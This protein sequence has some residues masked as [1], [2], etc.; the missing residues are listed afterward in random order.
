MFEKEANQTFLRGITTVDVAT[1]MDDTDIDEDTW[2]LLSLL[3]FF[4]HFNDEQ[5]FLAQKEIHKIMR[6]VK[7]QQNLDTYS[8]CSFASF[9]N[10]KSVP[11]NSP[12]F[13]TN[14]LN[15]RVTSTQNEEILS[16]YL[17]S[18]SVE[19]QKHPL[20]LSSL[21]IIIVPAQCPVTQI[22]YH[23]KM[24]AVILLSYLLVQQY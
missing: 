24:R 1:K 17:S 9:S 20:Q 10:A 21:S 7:R 12:H 22:S 14:P 19:P 15:P 5:I 3:P 8:S 4:S 23:A 16:Q 6:H 13:A 11:P 2:L 18:Y